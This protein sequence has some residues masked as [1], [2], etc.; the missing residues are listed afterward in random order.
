MVIDCWSKDNGPP[1]GVRKRELV[2]I[3]HQLRRTTPLM[4]CR[5]ASYLLPLD[6]PI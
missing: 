5:A 2:A 1:G 6:M 3:R 4:I